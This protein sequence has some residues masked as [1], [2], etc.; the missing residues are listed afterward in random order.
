MPLLK[1][2]PADDGLAGHQVVMPQDRVP[3]MRL[4][5]VRI[6]PGSLRLDGPRLLL[7]ACG[8]GVLLGTGQWGTARYLDSLS[9]RAGSC[10]LL[11]P[12]RR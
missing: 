7:G 5:A 6:M 3:S 9:M 8:R 12:V 11:F 4:V 2:V 1:N 10:R